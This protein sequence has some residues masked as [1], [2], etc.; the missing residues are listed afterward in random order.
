VCPPHHPLAKTSVVHRP[1]TFSY[2]APLH[3][4]TDAIQSVK[5]SL[6]VPAD[7]ASTRHLHQLRKGGASKA[8]CALIERSL[9]TQEGFS[10]VE[11]RASLMQI[12]EEAG[13]R[14]PKTEVV[15]SASDL[16]KWLTRF[17]FPLVLK[18][19]GT[20][21]GTG[22]RIAYTHEE[23]R[24]A[25]RELQA[26][27]KS[28]QTRT[29]RWMK[30]GKSLLWPLFRPR[31]TIVNAQAYVG[32]ND[33]ISEVACW[34][35]KVLSSLQ[36][37]VLSKQYASGPASV[38]RVIENEEMAI[39]AEKIVR[40]LGLS[41]LHGFDFILEQGTGNAYLTEM[42]PR[43]TQVG[44]LTLG[45]GRDLPAALYAAASRQEVRVSP[46]VTENPN[47]ALFPQE[48]IRN[49]ASRFLKSAYHDIPWEEPALVR[50]C[51]LSHPERKVRA[52]QHEE[53]IREL[54][55]TSVT[56]I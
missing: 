43:A 18:A 27:P 51:I 26:G 28:S 17:G 6:I 38:L 39:A 32:G 36:F 42:N 30:Q 54:S 16:E 10:I 11:R 44:H 14:T 40:R 50:A 2:T 49:R 45:P 23:A 34:D 25:F 4:L 53:W 22:V 12:A 31:R 5:P 29:Q 56:D 19:D 15:G 20:S 33:A 52:L 35:G 55:A 13:V 47:I 24:R 37:Q 7:D 3:S 9:G 46:K 8:I 21:G 1:L 41:G 48:W